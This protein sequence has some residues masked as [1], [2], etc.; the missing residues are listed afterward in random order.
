MIM[1]MS[2]DLVFSIETKIGVIITYI[3]YMYKCV[4]LPENKIF[5]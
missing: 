2:F 3:A 5:H 1:H 4:L